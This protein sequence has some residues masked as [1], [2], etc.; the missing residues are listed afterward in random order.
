LKKATGESTEDDDDQEF[1]VS[2]KSK[3]GSKKEAGAK[4]PTGVSVV[5][6]TVESKD[7]AEALTSKL[8][9]QYLIAD[10]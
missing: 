4:G 1:G 6:F 7:K 5:Q 9:G 3:A 10:S 2:K 8:L